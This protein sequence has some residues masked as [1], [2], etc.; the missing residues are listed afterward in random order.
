METVVTLWFVTAADPAGVITAEP[1]ADRGFGRKYLAQ[2]NPAWP[3]TPIGEFALN[4]SAQ[5]SAGEFYVAGFPGVTI[6]QT[7][8]T[9][10]PALSELDRRLLES[11]PAA[12][13]YAFGVNPATGYGALA[14]WQGGVLKRSLCAERTR[15][16]EDVGLPEPFEAPYWAG[17]KAESA[18]GIALPFEPVDLVA[19]ARRSWLGIDITPEG[20]DI[21]IVAYA[22]DGRPAPR[23]VDGPRL[24]RERAAREPSEPQV[25]G[26]YDDY[27][28]AAEEERDRLPRWADE[29]VAAVRRTG[30]GLSRRLRLARSWVTEKIRHS[31][32]G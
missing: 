9:D 8:L 16:Y 11:V 30:T 29:S 6:V 14:H 23:E 24:E 22:V 4:R 25:T 26:G 21:H 18:G 7:V 2:L 19:E 15:T 27:E 32:R 3:I 31:D 1:R 10:T 17:E 13:V 5:A 20:P 28:F 12:D